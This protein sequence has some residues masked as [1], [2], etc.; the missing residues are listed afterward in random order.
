MDLKNLIMNFLI[1][2]MTIDF[3]ILTGILLRVKRG[4]ANNYSG[5]VITGT[6]SENVHYP[7]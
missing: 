6:A 2:R 5:T 7:S 3:I 1:N 4:T